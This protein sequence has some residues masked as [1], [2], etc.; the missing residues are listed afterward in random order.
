VTPLLGAILTL[1]GCDR[2]GIGTSGADS[3]A[4]WSH[5]TD[6]EGINFVLTHTED[7]PGSRLYLGK[8][9]YDDRTALGEVI[10]AFGLGEPRRADEE[11]PIVDSRTA[12]Q[13]GFV[14]SNATEFYA[15][16]NPQRR[17]AVG[18]WVN[19]NAQVAIIADGPVQAF[20][21]VEAATSLRE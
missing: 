17:H 12:R 9:V 13:H 4:P 5:L 2:V 14:F 11:T 7:L 10:L 21:V 8:F 1:T 20:D 6:F 15:Y 3:E 16:H 18:M 19:T